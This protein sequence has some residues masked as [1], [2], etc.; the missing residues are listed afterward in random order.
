M[1]HRKYRIDRLVPGVGRIAIASGATT[2]KG[3]DRRN[4]VLDTLLDMARLDLL[5]AIKSGT[6]T[7]TEVLDAQREGALDRLVG[8]GRVLTRPLWATVDQWSPK[9]RKRRTAPKAV[10]VRRYK[11]AFQSLRRKGPL[12]DSATIGDLGKVDWGAL[13][14]SWGGSAADWNH[15]RRTV[16]RF[17]SDQLGDVQHPFR[18]DV[19]EAFPIRWETE[20][21]TDITPDVFWQIVDAAPEHVRAAY[22]VIVLAALDVGEYLALTK[23]D[24]LPNRCAIVAPGGKNEARTDEVLLIDPKMWEWVERGVPSAVQYGW[25]RKY[26][27]RALEAVPG[28]ST[29]WRLKDLRHCYA[30]WLTDAGQSEARVAVGMRHTDAKMTRRYAKQRDRGENAAVLASVLERKS[31]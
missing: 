30:Q 31:A 25:L 10:S 4:A 1:A 6:I 17:L 19:L 15:L 11:V 24:L 7:V 8:T 5:R 12:G 28:A 29:T 21:V 14:Q 27:K 2:K 18:R 22:V 20:R 16:S 23:E 13:E 26:F 9:A 3:F